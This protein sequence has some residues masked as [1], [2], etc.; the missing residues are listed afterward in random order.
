M[1]RSTVIDPVITRTG[2]TKIVA[3]EPVRATSQVVDPV[4]RSVGTTQTAT[5][6]PV[7]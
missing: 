2:G 1:P 5:P 6:E 3:P 7:E 4:C